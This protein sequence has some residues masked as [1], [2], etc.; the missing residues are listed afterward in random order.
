MVQHQILFSKLD[1]AAV[2]TYMTLKMFQ[3]I[4]KTSKIKWTEYKNWLRNMKLI[5]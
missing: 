5:N 3:K 1:Q 4:V 2:L